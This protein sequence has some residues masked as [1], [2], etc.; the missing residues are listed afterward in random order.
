MQLIDGVIEISKIQEMVP[1]GVTKPF[2]CRSFRGEE[3]IVKLEKNS[4]GT[5]VLINELIGHYIADLIGVTVP[6]YG[7]CHIGKDTIGIDE[8]FE[9]DFSES[10]FMG[11]GFYSAFIANTIPLA[12]RILHKTV[13]CDVSKIILLDCI[14]NNG[15]RH[16]GNLLITMTDE[17]KLYVIDFSHIISRDIPWSSD[18][19]KQLFAG[20]NL[21]MDFLND[22]EEVY[23]IL[24]R[25]R[26]FSVNNLRKEAD[27]VKKKVLE[28]DLEKILDV[29]PG[30]W[31]HGSCKNLAAD[32]I[33][34]IRR[35]A[36]KL[37]VLC[38]NIIEG[39]NAV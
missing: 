7:I 1:N 33:E 2:R 5:A 34:Y 32:I 14:L 28:S 13:N 31:N 30:A 9:D 6:P 18:R 26:S 29:I 24:F 36:N 12:E 11:Y 39:R 20:E 27:Y 23:N 15:D 25:H 37:E 4:F 17:P 8:Y 3:A 16:D 19:Q 38:Q 22:N 21:S 35:R 10:D